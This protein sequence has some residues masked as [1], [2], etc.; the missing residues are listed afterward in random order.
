MTAH[1]EAKLDDLHLDRDTTSTEFINNF[2]RYVRKLEAIEGP[3]VD[4]KKIQE[5]KDRV[6]DKDYDTE[7][8][9]HTG[10]FVDL[11]KFIPFA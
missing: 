10:T 7:A 9:V 6:T 4:A 2:E 5:F 11:I 8:R 3:W 1:Y